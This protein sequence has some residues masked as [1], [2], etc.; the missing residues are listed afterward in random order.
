MVPVMADAVV[1]KVV[2][3][4]LSKSTTTVYS[5]GA[6]LTA[7]TRSSLV[8]GASPAAT[9]VSSKWFLDALTGYTWG[10]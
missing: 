5:G 9:A 2:L 8:V 10:R 1:M 7:I 6:A 4:A 3:E